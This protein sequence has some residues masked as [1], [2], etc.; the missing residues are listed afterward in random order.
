MIAVEFALDVY[1]VR[2]SPAALISA[3]PVR[4]WRP[5]DLLLSPSITRRLIEEFTKAAG[6]QLSAAAAREP[7]RPGGRGPQ[8]DLRGLSAP[9]SSKNPIS[10]RGTV[11]LYVSP[12]LAKVPLRDRVQR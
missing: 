4:W 11:K 9:K 2:I 5:G 12:L 6:A 10:A 1:Q 7:D 8:A 3:I